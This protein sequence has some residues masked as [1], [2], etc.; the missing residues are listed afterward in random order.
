MASQEWVA[1]YQPHQLATEQLIVVT[2]RRRNGG[3]LNC[4]LQGWNLNLLLSL[5]ICGMQQQQLLVRAAR[6]NGRRAPVS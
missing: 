1:G 2:R 6:R 4:N 3:K 5:E